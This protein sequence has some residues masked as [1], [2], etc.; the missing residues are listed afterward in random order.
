MNRSC[1]LGAF[2]VSV[3]VVGIWVILITVCLL[4]HREI[5]SIPFH[6]LS[7]VLADS[8]GEDDFKTIEAEDIL[9]G[10]NQH[11]WEKHCQIS[12]EQLCNYPIFPKAPDKRSYVENADIILSGNAVAG[13]RL[14]GFLRPNVTGEYHFLVASNGFAEVSLGTNMNWKNARKIAYINPRY[15]TST[16][17]R[18]AFE[19]MKFQMSDRVT[20]SAKRKYFFEVM[21]VQVINQ[22]GD[23]HLIQVAWKRPDKSGFEI[24][25]AALFSPYKNDRDKA[26]MKVYDDDLP[27][28]SACMD[29]RRT[30]ANKFMRPER[31]PY[32]EHTSVKRTLDFCEYRPNYLL[33]PV[34]LHDF[35]QYH[36]VKRYTRKTSSYPFPEVDG[37]VKTRK[38]S[39][40]FIAEYPLDAKEAITV[41]SKYFEAIKRVYPR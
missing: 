34:D 14:L 10:L 37:V 40:T 16:L 36:G 17:K 6:N 25:D 2:V 26:E 12:L 5:P 15:S 31:L 33:K 9:K 18:M 11:T 7:S 30:S 28:V 41:V 23:K 8:I 38:V 27:E 19:A 1:I 24:I 35:K 21:Y 39:K 32:L 13:I 4:Y 3:L 29:L 22:E 20:L